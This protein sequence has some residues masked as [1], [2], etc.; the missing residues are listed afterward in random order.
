M[1][2]TKERAD[3]IRSLHHRAVKAAQAYEAATPGTRTKANKEAAWDRAEIAFSKALDW[4][5][6]DT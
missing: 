3:Q 2:L 1:P 4:D 6:D 5:A